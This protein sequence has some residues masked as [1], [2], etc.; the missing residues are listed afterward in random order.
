MGTGHLRKTESTISPGN[1]SIAWKETKA[2]LKD[3]RFGKVTFTR[4]DALKF[5]GAAGVMVTCPPFLYQLE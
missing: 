2:M 4:R 3:E 1:L 5:A